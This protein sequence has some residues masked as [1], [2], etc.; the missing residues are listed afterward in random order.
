VQP[1]VSIAAASTSNKTVPGPTG[2]GVNRVSDRAWAE[3]EWNHMRRVGLLFALG[4]VFLRVTGLHELVA[5]KLGMNTYILYLFGPPSILFCF[6]SGGL[7]RTFRQKQ[8]L[9]WMGFLFLFY[10]SILFS[11][12]RGNSFQIVLTYTR[13]EFIILPVVVGLVLTWKDF[14]RMSLTIAWAGVA[15]ILVGS[16]MAE[17]LSDGRSELGFG[18]MANSNDFAALVVFVLPF[19][20]LLVFTKR[21]FLI[22]MLALAVSLLGIY[23]ILSTGS[24]GALLALIVTLGFV[25]L[26]ASIRQK[27]GLMLAGLVAG[28]LLV[29]VL[30]D[31]VVSRLASLFKSEEEEIL[32]GGSAF[33]SRQSRTHLFKRSL[34]LTVKNPIFGVGPGQFAEVENQDMQEESGKKGS[35]HVTHNAYTQ[36]SSEAGIPAAGFFIWAIGST[37]LL[38]NRT[39][40]TALRRG[41]S[42][43]QERVA[44]TS[45]CCMSSLVGFGSV[46]MFLSLAYLFYFPLLTALA[47]A[48]HNAA[49]HEWRME[50]QKCGA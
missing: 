8:A 7:Q 49:E 18:T 14:W 20:A 44:I 5:S 36:V 3:V 21:N 41:Y 26:R 50:D 35:W 45:Y 43:F 23:R 29:A 12:W 38:M 27:I 13:T 25:F 30:P 40:R 28:S 48:M 24:R 16:A 37:L 22:R 46:C 47:L 31:T 4:L 19:V 2:L 32:T 39:H 33:M 15:T 17:Q 10:V 9:L 6:L 42:L 11:Y 34:E 1:S